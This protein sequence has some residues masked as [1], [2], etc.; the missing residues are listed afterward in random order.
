MSKRWAV[1]GSRTMD[2]RDYVFSQLDAV[3]EQLGEGPARIVSGGARGADALAVA[4]ACFHNIPYTEYLPRYDLLGK[5]APLVRNRE[6]IDDCD[7]V[8]AFPNSD[9][10]GTFHA[11]AYART[12][13]K[14][15]YQCPG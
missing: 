12:Q 13:G 10:R 1:I 14:P 2:D 6:I 7:L 5:G 3:R 11:I 8:V 9:S 4:Y 15:I